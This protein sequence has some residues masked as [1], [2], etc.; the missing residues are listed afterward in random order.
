MDI[1]KSIKAFAKK[2][3]EVEIAEDANDVDTMAALTDAAETYQA[4]INEK[5]ANLQSVQAEYAELKTSVQELITANAEQAKTISTLSE[6]VLK[7][8]TEGKKN[9]DD[10]KKHFSAELAKEKTEE[11]D[12]FQGR[13]DDTKSTDKVMKSSAF[14]RKPQTVK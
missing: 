3:F 14:G 2:V 5:I 9:V 6:E 7:I 11:N 8:Q 4:S 1:L 12:E 10:L 13:L